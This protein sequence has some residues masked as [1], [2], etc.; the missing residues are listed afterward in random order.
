MILNKSIIVLHQRN[1]RFSETCVIAEPND[2]KCKHTR[3]CINLYDLHDIPQ[4]G[5]K[6]LFGM[7]KSF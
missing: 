7:D 6:D 1:T 5:I 4:W 2:R 3:R